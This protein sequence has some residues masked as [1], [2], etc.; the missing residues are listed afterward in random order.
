[1][2]LFAYI[3]EEFIAA[4]DA[5]ANYSDMSTRVNIDSS[6]KVWLKKLITKSAKLSL[7]VILASTTVLIGL[8]S[9]LNVLTEVATAQSTPTAVVPS[10]STKYLQFL[11]S[12]NGFDPG[13]IDGVAG[14]STKNAIIRAQQALGLTA[15]GVAGSRTI[16][17]LEM[18]LEKSA[19]EPPA[20][21]SASQA[22]AP[23][24]KS[25]AVMNLQK[26]LADRGFYNG[27]VDGVM[28]SQTRAAI[29]AAQ[30]AYNL[31]PDGVAG[32]Q[33]LAALESGN[34][35]TGNNSTGNK[36]AVSSR[37]GSA[38]TSTASSNV[39]SAEVVVLQ[40]LLK[41]RGFY[42]GSSDG[43]MGPATR[44]AI[45][46]AQ[47]S[48]GLTADGIA[49]SQT[50]SA[51]ESGNSPTVETKSTTETKTTVETKTTTETKTTDDTNAS[52]VSSSTD[53]KAD[54]S[55]LAIQNLLAKRGFYD[56]AIDGLKGSMTSAAIV[57]AQKAYGLT[58]DGVA[59]SQ[60]LAA[61]EKD[62][63]KVA[64]PSA[65]QTSKPASSVNDDKVANLQNLL[66]DRGFYNGP[67]TGFL[68]SRT[69]EAIIA[70]QKAYGLT[71]D[72]VAGARTIAAL[73]SGSPRQQTAIS[74]PAP[75][76]PISNP[77][78]AVPTTIRVIPTP[79]AAAKPIPQP[80]LQPQIRVQP[81][82]QQTPQAQQISQAPQTPQAQA[83]TTPKPQV[84]Q[85]PQA[86]AQTT[87]KPQAQQIPQAQVKQALQAQVKQALQAQAQQAVQAQAQQ[88]PQPKPTVAATKPTVTS[89]ALATPNSPE[90]KPTAAAPKPTATSL[91]LATP[92][93]KP[94]PQPAKQ[95]A[96]SDAQVLELQNLLAKRG[97]YNGKV[98]GA[99]NGETRIAIDRAQ[100]FY[101][102]SPADGSI[103]NKLADS[104]RKDTF[105]S[106]DN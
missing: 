79:Q 75:A 80:D 103:S 17:A 16:T 82:A 81:Q 63:R 71:A 56:G 7:N 42:N 50:I 40:D 34:N 74:N 51:L 18:A 48:Y 33:T 100:N 43:L 61:L 90:P 24:P 96:A 83:Q 88:T 44:L 76:V 87:P 39:K 38:N 23:R 89:V 15:D 97:F 30:T 86:Q 73:E 93:A 70:A 28:G 5:I 14:A 9:T 77:A 104:L 20:N 84:Q 35:S 36:G 45:F 19:T 25:A 1:M 68:G 8:G 41:K 106:E 58:P 59:G 11:L 27:S 32:S 26:R 46:E 72:G 85:T 62:T 3:Q 2:E 65:N 49:G 54:K 13:E 37:N 66:A 64:N 53:K 52:E 98:D 57:A 6:F 67:T 22:E 94:S 102:I 4:D 92:S 95:P 47:K 10:A 31:T 105:I 69:K 99:L 91:A 12:K 78:P 21:S 29:V 55:L 60:T 101:T